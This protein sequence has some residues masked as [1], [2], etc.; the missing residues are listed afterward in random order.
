[1]KII[2]LKKVE[3]INK[4]IIIAVVFFRFISAYGRFCKSRIRN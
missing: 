3:K 4:T 1:M 2:K